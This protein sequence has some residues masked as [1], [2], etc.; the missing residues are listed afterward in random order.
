MGKVGLAIAGTLATGVLGAG[1][2]IGYQQLSNN[3]KTISNTNSNVSVQQA[4]SNTAN[5]TVNKAEAFKNELIG[6]WVAVDNPKKKATFTA[7]EMTALEDGKEKKLKYTRLSNGEIE[8]V[9]DG[10]KQQLKT[11]FEGEV[12]TITG[13]EAVKF[14]RESSGATTTNTN[15]TAPTDSSNPQTFKSSIGMEF[16]KIPAGS[17]QMGSNINPKEGPQRQVTLSQEFYLGK[18]EVTQEQYE[19]V[20][21]NNP[22]YFN[23]CPKCPAPLCAFGP[24]DL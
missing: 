18:T 21:G 2:F 20:M 3:S 6:T 12:L 11:T 19:K 24:Q 10:K 14:R 13:D 16:V 9:L 17:F 22:S 1:A 5:S 4:N 7:D 8:I 15:P 23:G